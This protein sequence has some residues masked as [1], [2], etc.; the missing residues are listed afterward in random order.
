MAQDESDPE[1]LYSI[2]TGFGHIGDERCLVTLIRLH[3]HPD[4]DLRFGVVFGL[5]RRP[6]A[7]ALDTLITLS[8][9][10][11]AR[12][13]DWS[14]YGLARHTDQ[15]FP[16]LRD[17]LAARLDDD[18]ADTRLEAVHGLAT[19]GDERVIQPLL[20][21]L[22]SPLEPADPGLVVE[23][24]YAL[25]TATADPRLRPHLLAERNSFLDDPI[26]EWP[27]GLRAALAK[28]RA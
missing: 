13:R 23:A 3:T 5:L 17:A 12:V 9:D 6:E 22:E 21:I 1:V 4:P 19:R 11:D 26:G 15:D 16:G 27:D 2:T 28:Y 7:A 20:D 18:D 14:T 10:E 25:A 8:A 24:L